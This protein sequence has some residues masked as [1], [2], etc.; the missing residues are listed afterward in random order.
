MTLFPYTTLFRS[1]GNGSV[2]GP[3]GQAGPLAVEWDP[4]TV[5]LATGSGDAGVGEGPDEGDFG[6]EGGEHDSGGHEGG[7]GGGAAEH[8]AAKA[9]KEREEVGK[10]RHLYCVDCVDLKENE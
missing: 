4:H 3:G 1:I 5:S 10:G 2:E 7:P 6:G 9:E 8:W